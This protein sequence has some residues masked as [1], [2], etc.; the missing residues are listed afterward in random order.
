MPR[1]AQK[2][3]DLDDELAAVIVSPVQMAHFLGIPRRTLYDW[4][5]A[6]CPRH[7]AVKFNLRNVIL[8]RLDKLS[9]KPANRDPETNPAAKEIELKNKKL[10][11]EIQL[12]QI[13]IQELEK[14]S[15][16]R[17]DHEQVVSGV[18]TAFVSFVKDSLFLNLKIIRG[19]TDDKLP[20]AIEEFGNQ[21]LSHL[22]R[23]LKRGERDASSNA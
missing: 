22:Q 17:V 20:S 10:E 7:D 19:V 21:L 6:G 18:V 13:K 14:S 9:L 11:N 23:A 8:W 16:P 12:Q 1:S 15:M 3:K 5:D 4:V 2:T